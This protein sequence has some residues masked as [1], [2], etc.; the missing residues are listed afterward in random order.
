M[1]APISPIRVEPQDNQTILLE[2]SNRE[3]F[4]VPYFELRFHCP[5]ANCVDEKSG[6][7][8]LK[9]EMVAKDVRPISVEPVGRYALRIG[10]SD[11]HATGIFAYETLYQICKEAG[12]V[13]SR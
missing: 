12:T 5:C 3:S 10:F 1:T 8:T 6:K 11:Q 13:L 9:R 7:R 4:T 2:W